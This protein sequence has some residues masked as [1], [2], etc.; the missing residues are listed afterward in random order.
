LARDQKAVDSEQPCRIEREGQI[1]LFLSSEARLIATMLEF[2]RTEHSGPSEK[3]LKAHA[4]QQALSER[5]TE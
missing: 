3:S 5:A 2:W 1:P 4:R